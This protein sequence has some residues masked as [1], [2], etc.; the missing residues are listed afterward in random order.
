MQD[1]GRDWSQLLR[2]PF[3]NIVLKSAASLSGRHGRHSLALVCKSWAEAVAAH[4]AIEDDICIKGCVTL[5]F[6]QP[7]CTLAC[8]CSNWTC[9]YSKR[10]SLNH[11]CHV[12]VRLGILSCSMP[13]TC[14]HVS[15]RHLAFHDADGGLNLTILL[16]LFVTTSAGAPASTTSN[17]GWSSMRSTCAK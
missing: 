2:P 9:L 5:A 6:A 8:L 11:A 1:A 16:F 10:L 3:A 7:C 13:C 4:D 17:A 14:L 15:I 12:H